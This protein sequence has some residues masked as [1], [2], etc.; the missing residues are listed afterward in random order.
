MSQTQKSAPRMSHAERTE[1]S[2]S[3]MFAAAVASIVRVGTERTKLKDV[4]ENAGYSRGLAGSRFKSKDGL[5]CYVIQ[6]VAEDWLGEVV[7]ATS[8]KSGYEAICDVTDAH[9]RFCKHAP[10]E[11]R[12]FYILWFESVGL[13]SEVQRKIVAIH[14]KREQVIIRWIEQGIAAGELAADID[15][16]AVTRQYLM[17][18]SGIIY[19]WLIDPAKEH[20]IQALHEDLKTTMRLL[21][22]TAEAGRPA[23]LGRPSQRTS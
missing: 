6:R 13:Q 15:A 14:E 11:F 17:A 7:A 1:L 16:V 19:Q 18:I 10:D 21:L 8:G 2:D 5:F 4:G 22:P 12:A 3:R 23:P 9:Y 20:E